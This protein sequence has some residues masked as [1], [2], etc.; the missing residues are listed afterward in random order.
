MPANQSLAIIQ[1][2]ILSL[3]RRQSLRWPIIFEFCALDTITTMLASIRIGSVAAARSCVGP[4]V[5]KLA[6]GSLTRLADP[7]IGAGKLF[8]TLTEVDAQE[9]MEEIEASVEAKPNA[10]GGA[11]YEWEDPFR[12]KN[13]LTEEEVSTMQ[14]LLHLYA[15]VC[16]RLYFRRRIFS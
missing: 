2:S 1:L 12:L 8:S 13:Q 4:A 5:K 7:S 9:Q 10:F 15:G 11:P 14:V 3:V 16:F 6:L